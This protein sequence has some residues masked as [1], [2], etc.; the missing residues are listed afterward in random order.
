MV[1]RSRAQ[2]EVIGIILLT[3]VVLILVVGAGGLFLSG[4]E[5]ETDRDPLAD[6][7]SDVNATVVTLDHQG[8]DGFDAGDVEVVLR[9]DDG[10]FTERLDGGTFL[11]GSDDTRF[12]PGD[13]W[14]SS[15]HNRSGEVRLFV[16]DRAS[17][18]VLHEATH[19]AEN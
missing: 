8:G 18:T 16:V 17:N 7:E 10:E 1:G 4:L 19:E 2:S 3:A 11:R 5:S 12:V 15:P 13:R 14:R 6:L 9:G